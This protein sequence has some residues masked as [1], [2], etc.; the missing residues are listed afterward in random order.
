MRTG[1]LF[2]ILTLCGAL[3]V[4]TSCQKPDVF[5]GTTDN[6][7]GGTSATGE[8]A[9]LDNRAEH[10]AAEG[11]STLLHIRTSADW[12][13]SSSQSWCRPYV[14]QGKGNSD[15]M[16][17]LDANTTGAARTAVITVTAGDKRAEVTLIQNSGDQSSSG[18]TTPD[19]YARRIEIPRLKGGAMN[20][21]IVHTVDYNGKTVVN[22]SMEYSNAHKGPWWVAFTFDSE[23]N[24]KN[25]KRT[26]AWAPD[27]MVDEAYRTTSTDYQSPYNRGHLCASADRVYSKEANQQTFYYSNMS[28]Q[29]IEFNSGIWN[30]MENS[31]RTYA[32]ALGAKDTLYVAKGGSLNE[33]QIKEYTGNHV[34]VPC[35]YYMVM[36]LLKNGKYQGMAYWVNQFSYSSSN[37]GDYRTT[38]DEV[39]RQTGI[40]FFPNLPDSIEAA[41]EAASSW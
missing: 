37:P 6:G 23:T 27:V 32:D 11:G 24:K 34:A 7:N 38:I 26:D 2:F 5:T 31:V 18:G 39:E 8:W 14:V 35:F 40:D 28:P 30:N 25:T 15:V 1:S 21:F 36:V 12:N 20:K 33:D 22:Y 19:R 17:V 3:S 29:L 4:C 9:Y 10:A 41:V 13:L 16:L